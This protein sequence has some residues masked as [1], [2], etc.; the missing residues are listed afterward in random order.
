MQALA[1]HAERQGVRAGARRP[2]DRSAAGSPIS[3]SNRGRIASRTRASHAAVGWSI[4]RSIKARVPG[5]ALLV[6]RITLPQEVADVRPQLLGR[7]APTRRRIRDTRGSAAVRFEHAPRCRAAPCRRS[8][9]SPPPVLGP[10]RR[11]IVRT[12]AARTP[13]PRTPRP[14]PPAAVLFVGSSGVMVGLHSDMRTT[15]S[16]GCFKQLYQ[17][18]DSRQE[19]NW[20]VS[21]GK[22]GSAYVGPRR[23][24]PGNGNRR[25]G[26]FLR[27]AR[28]RHPGSPMHAI[29]F[30]KDP[31]KVPV[32]PVY[33]LFGDDAFLR[34]ESLRE[35]RR[36]AFPGDDADAPVKRV[37]GRF[38]RRWPTC[39]TNFGPCL[40]SPS[41]GWWWSRLPTRLSRL[42]AR[43]WRR[44]SS[45]RRR[46]A[47]SCSS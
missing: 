27:S 33:A 25:G 21:G 24:H 3:R 29:D 16:N 14:P 43:S 30:L 13:S 45:N 37:R 28:A 41:A 11:Q 22:T 36:S 6:H 20:T 23:W 7:A 44:M 35:V 1:D 18:A 17:M 34:K 40:S 39:S 47:F 42:T 15:V 32:K 26:K 2:R 5:A 19:R 9:S 4:S 12:R 10:A 8:G 46:T 38:R 31:A